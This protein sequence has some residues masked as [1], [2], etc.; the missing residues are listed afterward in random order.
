M[1]AV[2]VAG[3]VNVYSPDAMA[4]DA[5]ASKQPVELII[6]LLIEFI[7]KSSIIATASSPQ[8]SLRYMNI[9]FAAFSHPSCPAVSRLLMIFVNELLSH[10]W[11][12]SSFAN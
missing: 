12:I 1:D 11:A 3:S 6:S 2:F 8:V 4:S 7:V 10:D 9:S 5:V